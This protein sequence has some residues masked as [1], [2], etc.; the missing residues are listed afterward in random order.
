MWSN[1]FVKNLKQSVIGYQSV[2]QGPRVPIKGH[3]WEFVLSQAAAKSRMKYEWSPTSHRPGSDITISNTRYSCK[4]SRFA[5]DG[6][7]IMLSSYRLTNQA[8]GTQRDPF[9]NEI[10]VVRHNFDFYAI[11]VRD[12]QDDVISKYTI[13]RVPA[14][15]LKAGPL[16]WHKEPN[17]NWI[18]C[19]EDY[20]MKIVRSTAHQLWVK[21]P[22]DYIEDDRVLDIE[23]GESIR[24]INLTDI[25]QSL[26]KK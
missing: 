20:S 10:D 4:T 19:G 17:G 23:I 7:Y 1:R 12:Q 21:V 5:E 16:E 6:D 3:N 9:I 2:M 18:G 8:S 26:Y 13:Y 15:R 24:P 22:L 11:L 25:Y 14:N